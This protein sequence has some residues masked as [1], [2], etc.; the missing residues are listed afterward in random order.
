MEEDGVT[1]AEFIKHQE[2]NCEQNGNIWNWLYKTGQGS[3]LNM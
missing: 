2:S 3:M 1:Y